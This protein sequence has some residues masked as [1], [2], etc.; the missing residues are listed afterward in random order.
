MDNSSV[1]AA[2]GLSFLL[3]VPLLTPSLMSVF[4]DISSGFPVVLYTVP[5]TFDVIPLGQQQRLI[6][7]SLTISPSLVNVRF[8]GLVTVL[9]S[10]MHL[11]GEHHLDVLLRGL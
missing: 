11:S 1:V 5:S 4:L 9:G 8:H 2:A 3:L 10:E 7:K 6:P